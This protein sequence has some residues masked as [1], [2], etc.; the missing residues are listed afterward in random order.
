MTTGR[1]WASL[2][3]AAIILAGVLNGCQS[4]SPAVSA[5]S[6]GSGLDPF[7]RDLNAL[8]TGQRQAPVVVLQIGDSHTAGDRF[9]GRLRAQLQAR[10]GDAGRGYLQPGVPFAYYNPA[11][12]LA[13]QSDGW[14]VANSLSA[15]A[16]GPFGLA[17]YRQTA[18]GAGEVMVLT[19]DSFAGFDRAWLQIAA[20]PGGGRLL[21]LADGLPVTEIG[22]DS[23]RPEARL[24]T[25]TIPAGARSLR[26]E[27]L[28]D[29]PTSI[30]GWGVG[31]DQP[32]VE[33]DAIGIGGATLSV[34]DRWAP[35][36]VAAEIAD[37]DPSLIILAFGTNEGFDDTL[38]L[39]A[40]SDLWR[41]RLGQVRRWAPN[42]AIAVIG[43][44]DGNRRARGCPAIDDPDQAICAPLSQVETASY[45]DLI[46]DDGD[47]PD[48]CRWHPPPSLAQVRA[49]QQQA[50][51]A[52]GAWFWDWSEVMGGACGIHEWVVA[53]T[54]L[55]Y[56][57]HVHMRDDGY[58]LSADRFYSALMERYRSW[59]GGPVAEAPVS[60]ASL[61]R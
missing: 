28:D 11:G 22:T 9:S 60:E 30:A 59:A 44:P 31:R 61:P 33:L 52:Q 36:R 50:A 19:S 6:P 51:A 25:L 3:M 7:F 49:I 48:L 1:R 53:A 40:Y 47:G 20:Q 32:G 29:A 54:P 8:E 46:A 55:A 57:D 56:G 21:V 41:I 45:L 23:D 35:D 27:T 34:I 26:V 38:D 17:G 13:E 2:A 14:D 18:R 4:S 43:P 5:A 12:V 37:R 58:V 39:A 15:S 16:I 42:A 10:F 24:V